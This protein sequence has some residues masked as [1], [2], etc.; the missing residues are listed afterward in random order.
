MVSEGS[1]IIEGQKIG[2]VGATGNARG[3]KDGSH[4]HFELIIDGIKQ[5]PLNHFIW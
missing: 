1:K 2:L 3:K 5:D 4:L